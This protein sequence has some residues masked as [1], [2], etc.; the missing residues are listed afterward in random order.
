METLTVEQILV[1]PTF[2]E[3][4]VNL[5][6][7]VDN[8]QLKLEELFSRELPIQQIK[9]SQA[10]QNNEKGSQNLVMFPITHRDLNGKSTISL[11]SYDYSPMPSKSKLF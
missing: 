2:D 8:T 7:F 9:K 5:R 11:V 6:S 10:E 4:R 1:Q 3:I